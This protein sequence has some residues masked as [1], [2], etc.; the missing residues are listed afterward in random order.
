MIFSLFLIMFSQ[1]VIQVVV[2]LTALDYIMANPETYHDSL[3][4]HEETR[5]GTSKYTFE[6]SVIT[7]SEDERLQV[8]I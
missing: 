4:C 8:C 6:I 5:F 3:S 7:I 2:A 1:Y